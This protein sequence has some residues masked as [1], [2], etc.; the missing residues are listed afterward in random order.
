MSHA[1]SLATRAFSESLYSAR[2][3]T[4]SFRAQRGICCSGIIPANKSRFLGPKGNAALGMTSGVLYTY[5]ENG[6]AP[7]PLWRIA[8]YVEAALDSFQQL[9]QLSLALGFRS[10]QPRQV[11]EPAR[12]HGT[13]TCRF[14]PRYVEGV[15]AQERPGM[16]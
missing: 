7:P 2:N 16:I 12:S 3:A 14:M 4:V 8:N 10:A 6:L 5:R 9:F 15:I 1:D 11:D 13:A